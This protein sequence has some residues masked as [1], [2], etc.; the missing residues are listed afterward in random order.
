VLTHSFT[1]GRHD[2]RAIMTTT[3]IIL[4]SNRP[5]RTSSF[6]NA[7]LKFR[8]A[9]FP[10]QHILRCCRRLFNVRERNGKGERIAA[11]GTVYGFG[12]MTLGFLTGDATCFCLLSGGSAVLRSD[13]WRRVAAYHSHA[14]QSWLLSSSSVFRI[15]YG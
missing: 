12:W 10:S 8:T 4:F 3:S 15:R 2:D 5:S 6:P 7:N 13:S 9:S 14:L 11:A 1:W